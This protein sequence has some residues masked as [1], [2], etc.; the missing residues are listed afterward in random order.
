MKIDKD[1][2]NRK[3]QSECFKLGIRI[4]LTLVRK[5]QFF[6][7]VERPNQASRNSGELNEPSSPDYVEGTLYSQKEANLK[8][9][10]LYHFFT[11]IKK[12]VQIFDFKVIYISGFKPKLSRI[13]ENF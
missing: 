9:M 12:Q 4:F 11:G 5:D 2:R 3:A 7:T 13:T 1:Y 6:V 10:E 8:V